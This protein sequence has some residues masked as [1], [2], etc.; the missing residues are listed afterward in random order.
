MSARLPV[1]IRFPYWKKVI[2]KV[3][4]TTNLIIFILINIKKYGSS[5]FFS[6]SASGCISFGLPRLSCVIQHPPED[7][8]LSLTMAYWKKPFSRWRSLLER[9]CFRFWFSLP[10]T[11]RDVHGAVLNCTRP[12]EFQKMSS[13]LIEAPTIRLCVLFQT[14]G[15]IFQLLLFEFLLAP[16]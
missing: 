11:L 6:W 15:T 9:L 12:C 2:L 1:V 14:S 8:L 4:T 7:D 10:S 16:A 13:S 3:L 5:F